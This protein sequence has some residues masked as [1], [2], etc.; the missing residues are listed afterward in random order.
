MRCSDR[1]P[2]LMMR[3]PLNRKRPTNRAFRI[4]LT[5]ESVCPLTGKLRGT[6]DES[7]G[8]FWS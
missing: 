3:A 1:G 4:C 2:T 6:H 7:Y 5:R 8:S